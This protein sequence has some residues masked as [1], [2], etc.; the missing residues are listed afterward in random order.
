MIRRGGRFTLNE[1]R[2]M[3]CLCASRID[4]VLHMAGQKDCA[5]PI[6]Y[7]YE[8][9]QTK[10]LVID[11]DVKV[12]TTPKFR[13]RRDFEEFLVAV[14][15]RQIFRPKLN[16]HNCCV[17]IDNVIHLVTSFTISATVG[18]GIPV[19]WPADVPE[20][21]VMNGMIIAADMT[22]YQYFTGSGHFYG[23]PYTQVLILEHPMNIMKAGIYEHP[24]NTEASRHH[25][26]GNES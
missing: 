8:M 15:Q 18:M 13:R 25:Y 11:V 7:V 2:A 26:L 12:I 21:L 1:P 23:G 22:V 6:T 17:I 20:I 24:T 9:Y 4:G 5:I 3:V 14:A 10:H 16:W 19:A